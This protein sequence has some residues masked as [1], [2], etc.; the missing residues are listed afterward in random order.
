M[1]HWIVISSLAFTVF[2]IARSAPQ[3]PQRVNEE[4]RETQHINEMQREEDE[5]YNESFERTREDQ[6]YA[7]G[8]KKSAVPIKGNWLENSQLLLSG[9]KDGM[10]HDTQ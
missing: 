1:N 6:G 3:S 7:S 5:N 10:K 8:E 2:V 4:H 9:Q